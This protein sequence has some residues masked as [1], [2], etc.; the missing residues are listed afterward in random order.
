[1]SIKFEI[2]ENITGYLDE[3]QS[4]FSRE[5]KF[6]LNEMGYVV[7]GYENDETAPIPSLMSTTFNP[8]LY[9]SGQMEENRIFEDD[10]EEPSLEI[11]YSGMGLEEMFPDE[12]P[13]GV[14]WEFA[15]DPWNPPRFR[16]LERDYAL[17]QE[18]GRDTTAKYS[19]ARHKY[20]IRTGLTHYS[21][22]RKIREEAKRQFE[23][24]LRITSK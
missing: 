15:E 1:M 21:S 17:Y 13:T 22:Q 24:I 11:I 23:R 14:W 9:L 3:L 10:P 6:I 7:T 4:N 2:E 19:D 8:F 18:T 12:K 5:K 20:A 16:H